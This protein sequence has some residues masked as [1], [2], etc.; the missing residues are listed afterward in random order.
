MKSPGRGPGRESSQGPKTKPLLAETAVQATATVSM[1]ASGPVAADPGLSEDLAAVM[2]GE[3]NPKGVKDRD[4]APTFVPELHLLPAN[5]QALWPSLRPVRDQGFVLYGG[6]AVSLRLGHR[7]SVDFDFFSERPFDHSALIAALPFRGRAKVIQEAPNTLTLLVAPE[8]G[9]G[10][11]VKVSFF[12]GLP[13]GRV[14]E[15]EVTR[16]GVVLAAS[17]LD[18]MGSKLKVIQQRAEKKDYIDI[19]KMLEHGVRLD[20][21][22]AAGRVLY[23]RTFQPSEA[24]KA[25]TYFGD[26]N[27]KEIPNNIREALIKASTSV[28]SVPVLTAV[29][30]SLGLGEV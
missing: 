26:G 24:L 22:L 23:G 29:S 7:I 6:T 21:G 25:M 13:L 28:K 12:G 10:E 14:G 16:D 9:A 11:G 18:L 15:P 17:L 3:Q 1:D 19:H 27:L 5:Q 4:N 2:S 8:D 20:E 30:S